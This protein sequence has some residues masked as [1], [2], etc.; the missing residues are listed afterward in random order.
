MKLI[1]FKRRYIFWLSLLGVL[2]IVS[3]L[4]ID[5][6]LNKI[7]NRHS[8][9]YH[10]EKGVN[11]D[12]DVQASKYLVSEFFFLRIKGMGVGILLSSLLFI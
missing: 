10:G 1:F 4:L 8:M 6:S 11:N 9:S 3:I 2:I 12:D 5:N 7:S